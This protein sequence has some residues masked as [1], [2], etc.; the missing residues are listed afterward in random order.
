MILVI[1]LNEL[2][3]SYIHIE[4]QLEA[5]QFTLKEFVLQSIEIMDKVEL[6]DSRT[7]AASPDYYLDFTTPMSGIEAKMESTGHTQGLDELSENVF[8]HH[9]TALVLEVYYELVNSLRLYKIT[10]LPQIRRSAIGWQ[11]QNLVL[12]VHRNC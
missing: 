7:Y 9:L 2:L 11:G 3:A 12:K 10:E 4:P 6:A 1:P 5:S 8:Q